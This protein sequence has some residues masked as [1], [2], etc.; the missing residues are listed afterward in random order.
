MKLVGLGLSIGLYVLIVVH[1][2]A[3]FEVICPL[4][5]KRIGTRFGIV[6]CAIG[7]IILY[8]IIFNHFFAM[9]IS[10]G[11]PKDLARIEKLR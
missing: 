8:N 5:K 1:V 9:S 10:P 2:Y 11:N 4:L 3:Y 7:L 6:W